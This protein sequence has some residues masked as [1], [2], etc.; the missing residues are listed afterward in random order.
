[1]RIGIPKEILNNENRVAVSPSGV[2]SLTEAGHEVFVETGA[3]TGANFTDEQYVEVGAVIVDDPGDAWAQ[4]MVL[5]VK[6]PQEA[7]YQYLRE[8]L[9]LFT[10]LHLANE[11]N[12][13]KALLENKVTG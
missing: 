6:E 9:I 2:Y 4:D 7:E 5:K 1:M 8:D 13:T 12:L 11:L 10:Y 3:G